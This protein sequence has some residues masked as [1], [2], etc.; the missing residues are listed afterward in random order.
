MGEVEVSGVSNSGVMEL[1]GLYNL[2]RVSRLRIVVPA[3]W[4]QGPEERGVCGGCTSSGSRGNSGEREE[5]GGKLIMMMNMP[6]SATTRDSH[7][8]RGLILM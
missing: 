8:Q 2:P 1:F 7:S 6:L 5:C 4:R 3:R